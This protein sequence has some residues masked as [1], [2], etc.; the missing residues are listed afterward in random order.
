MWKEGVGE[1]DGGKCVWPTEKGGR[2]GEEEK[3]WQLKCNLNED[4]ESNPDHL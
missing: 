4:G 3:I 1:V 2:E